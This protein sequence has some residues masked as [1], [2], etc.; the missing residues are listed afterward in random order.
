M[1]P[2]H[3]RDD[4]KNT[5]R[6][7]T[8]TQTLTVDRPTDS[9]GQSRMAPAKKKAAGPSQTRIRD[10]FGDTLRRVARRVCHMPWR[11]LTRFPGRIQQMKTV[12]Q[13][14][15]AATP[16]FGPAAPLSSSAQTNGPLPRRN[17]I[18][19]PDSEGKEDLKLAPKLHCAGAVSGIPDSE[20]E[21]QIELYDEDGAL[22]LSP[23]PHH[24]TTSTTPPLSRPKR[25]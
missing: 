2:H 13:P 25:S 4:H 19:V 22:G 9:K 11:Q 8:Y 1:A 7:A 10:G 17:S 12:R 18:D 16:S 24:R 14:T 21:D 3:G 15:I 5:F 23:M 6:I 20:A